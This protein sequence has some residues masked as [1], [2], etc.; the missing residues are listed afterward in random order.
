MSEWGV[1]CE[2]RLDAHEREGCSVAFSFFRCVKCGAVLEEILKDGRRWQFL[3]T[4][5]NPRP[6][7]RPRP[8]VPGPKPPEMQRCWV[9]G[10]P[11]DESQFQTTP[12][13]CFRCR[14]D[15]EFGKFRQSRWVRFLKWLV[16]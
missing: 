12:P 14:V 4:V 6:R 9:C 1:A 10:D 16:R 13:V 11:R 5:P 2:A 3:P 8:T 7:G 15:T